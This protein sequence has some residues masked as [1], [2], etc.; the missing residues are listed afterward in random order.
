MNAFLDKLRCSLE[1]RRSVSSGITRKRQ[2]NLERPE[3]LANPVDDDHNLFVAR[4]SPRVAIFST[5]RS[6]NDK[7]RR[8]R[9]AVQF[10]RATSSGW[11]S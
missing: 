6:C 7:R 8:H 9:G 5:S 10:T 4:A 1:Y 11:R 2:E 3:A